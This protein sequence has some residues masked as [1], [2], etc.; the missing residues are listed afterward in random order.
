[1]IIDSNGRVLD[2]TIKIST[3]LK[4]LSI[5]DS[6]TIQY[7]Y[8]LDEILGGASLSSR[9]VLWESWSGHVGGSVVYPTFGG[10]A[11]A[12][13]RMTGLL[14]RTGEGMPAAN[15]EKGK[16]G[17][18]SM[19]HVK[20]FL[21]HEQFGLEMVRMQE[22]AEAHVKMKKQ[23]P[24][25]SRD[26]AFTKN[27]VNSTP[28][29][30]KF[31]VVIFR[32]MHGWMNTDEI[33][34]NRFLEAMQLSTELFGVETVILQTIPFTNNVKT[35]DDWNAIN[36]I[37]DMMRDIAKS[38]NTQNSAPKM[39]KHILVQEY[40][41]YVN[42]I[43]W[44]NARYLGYNVSDPLDATH[45]M[46]ITEGPTFLFDRLNDGKEWSPSIPMVCSDM[47]SLGQ[48]RDKCNRNYLFSDG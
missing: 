15:K 30:K 24:N 31:D 14:S 41:Q 29:L 45:E 27:T 35:E 2:F 4:L 3:S 36:R 44:S 46:F 20:R 8:S 9:T 38:W 26:V 47:E 37:N 16:G 43:I 23:S 10:G 40:G 19:K 6:V 12:T 11:S 21:N 7:S 17:G 39:P 5:G 25:E 32:T 48:K 34:A 33:T 28:S 13:W 22:K 1:L 18:W 42:H